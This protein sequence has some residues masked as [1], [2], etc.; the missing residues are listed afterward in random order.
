MWYLCNYCSVTREGNDSMLTGW[1]CDFHT[2]YGFG[3]NVLHHFSSLDLLLAFS[4]L[5]P[6]IFLIFAA[7]F[8]CSQM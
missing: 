7:C 1:Q 3:T 8:F 5:C 4:L 6:C 2:G